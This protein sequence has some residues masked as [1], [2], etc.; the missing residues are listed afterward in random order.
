MKSA[1]V[2]IFVVATFVIVILVL[3]SMHFRDIYKLMMDKLGYD[4]KKSMNID[5][6]ADLRFF[7]LDECINHFW[8]YRVVIYHKGSITDD[9]FT[10]YGS[11]VSPHNEQKVLNAL[12]YICVNPKILC[13]VSYYKV[14]CH[15][16]DR[17]NEVIRNKAFETLLT[18]KSAMHK[19]VT[20]ECIQLLKCMFIGCGRDNVKSHAVTILCEI[21][22]SNPNLIT[23]DIYDMLRSHKVTTSDMSLSHALEITLQEIRQNCVHLHPEIDEYEKSLLTKCLNNHDTT[24]IE[25]G[26]EVPNVSS[27]DFSSSNDISSKESIIQYS[28]SDEDIDTHDDEYGSSN[29]GRDDNCSRSSGSIDNNSSS[30][31]NFCDMSSDSSSSS[32]SKSIDTN[33]SS[34]INFIE[35]CSDSSSSSS[36][37][38]SISDSS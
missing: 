25:H 17:K 26:I 16:A 19:C 28:I 5:N 8:K 27:S 13:P 18:C 4:F 10:R 36:S 3:I 35:M 34:E 29:N 38:D 32:S 23:F 11:P 12:N 2:T 33:S 1:V 6:S 20:T 15:M 9:L 14:V 30:E 7:T 24:T 37:S 31:I 21:S 22:H